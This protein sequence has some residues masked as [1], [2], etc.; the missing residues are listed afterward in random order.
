VKEAKLLPAIELK[1]DKAV[2]RLE[3]VKVPNQVL[4]LGVVVVWELMYLFFFKKKKKECKPSLS[5]R[6]NPNSRIGIR[7]ISFC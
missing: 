6:R 1:W 2:L 7:S 5:Q 4:N 3:E